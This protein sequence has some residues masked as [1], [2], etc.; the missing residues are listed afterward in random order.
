MTKYR[1]GL[2]YALVAFLFASPLSAQIVQGVLVDEKSQQI[3]H[4]A[5][6]SL[7]DD[8]GRVVAATTLDSTSGAFYLDAGHAGRYRLRFLVGRGGLSYSPLFTVDSNQTVEHKYAVPELPQAM[9]DAFLPDDVSTQA[10]PARGNRAPRYPD[11]LRAAGRDGIARV[12]FVV[13]RDGRPITSTYRVVEADDPA[14]AQAIRD[15][16]DGMRF[17]PAERDGVKVPQVFELD[18]DFGFGDTPSRLSSKNG[19]I[20][21][22][23]GVTRR[24]PF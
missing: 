12:L 11:R 1:K 24:T 10:A 14:F 3:I 20:I 2:R 9:L 5:H 23:L 13:D 8:S 7:V 18:A 15:A 19:M 6:V 16:L 4:N 17:I 21:R 22:A